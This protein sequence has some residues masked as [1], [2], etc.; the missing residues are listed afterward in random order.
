MSEITIKVELRKEEGRLLVNLN[1]SAPIE[2]LETLEDLSGPGGVPL[3]TALKHLFGKQ[4]S[5]YRALGASEV[6]R[7]HPRD[8]EFNSDQ[9]AGFSNFCKE[10][11]GLEQLV[12]ASPQVLEEIAKAI[13]ERVLFLARRSAG[14]QSVV[15]TKTIPLDW[16]KISLP[17]LASGRLILLGPEQA[18]ELHFSP[19]EGVQ[20]LDELSASIAQEYRELTQSMIKSLKER[21]K[22]ALEK[23]KERIE[24]SRLEGLLLGLEI[25]EQQPWRIDR[26][27]GVLV[28]PETIKVKRIRYKKRVYN[29][30]T[31][32]FQIRGL[33]VPVEGRVSEASASEAYHPNV[34]IDRSVCLG[35]LEDA[36]LFE[37]LLRLP[38]SLEVANL[39]SCYE[40]RASEEA[41]ELVRGEKPVG[42]VEEVVWVSGVVV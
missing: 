37:V 40:N 1:T 39:D 5:F 10:R 30:E 18:Y 11:W 31:E 38:A 6:D 34:S 19:L 9:C 28:Y 26:R 8:A 15:I 35:T 13:L 7:F 3:S 42:V 22:E 16:S 14:I 29:I 41:L 33:Q 2:A 20:S 24:E 36:P 32:K 25:S 21:H 17:T 23:M 12:D 27:K 4:A